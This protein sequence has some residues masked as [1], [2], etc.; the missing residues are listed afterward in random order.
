MRHSFVH[1]EP[2]KRGRT[3]GAE[4]V[5]AQS[6]EAAASASIRELVFIGRPREILFYQSRGEE[7]NLK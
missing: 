6:K 2:L 3:F 4:L 7:N 5:A 1:S